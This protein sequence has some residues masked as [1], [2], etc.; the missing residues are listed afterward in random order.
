MLMKVIYDT[1]KIKRKIKKAVLAIG[2][3]DSLHLGHQELIRR[4]VKKAKRLKGR[5]VVMTFFPHPVHVLRPEINLPL[6]ISLDHRIKL[7]KDLGVDI[8]IVINFTK[9]FSR[10]SAHDFIKRYLEKSLDLKE[11]FV[12]DDFRFGQNRAGTLEIFKE[13]GLKTRFKVNV[14]LPVKG[15]HGKISSTEIR[16]LISKGGLVRAK[17][18]L[19][20][21]VSIMGKVQKGERRGK[22]LGFPTANIYPEGELMVPTGVYAV[23]V[24]VN[25]KQ[26]FGMANVGLRPSF[27]R[28]HQ[29]ENVEVHIF[30][31]S[32]QLY[33]KVII[34]EFIKKIRKE[35]KYKSKE[36]LIKQ[37]TRDRLKVSIILKN[38]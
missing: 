23:K 15:G 17:K 25:Q 32:R 35:K 11:V 34:V 29:K 6:I 5:S 33:G 9:R 10:L 21:H 14:V 38:S 12:G 8:C 16:E 36:D 2:V 1:G 24:L 13:I 28:G 7:I 30:N 20:R 19:G 18:L 3:F 22:R 31:F 4:A 37:I 27:S 26:Y